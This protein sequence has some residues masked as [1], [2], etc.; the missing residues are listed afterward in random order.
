MSY[1]NSL[2]QYRSLAD[3]IRSG[4]YK[5]PAKQKA[6][7]VKQGLVA[8]PAR[9]ETEETQEVSR[10]DKP[11]DMMMNF[12]QYFE[13]L[14]RRDEEGVDPGDGFD[15][16]STYTAPRP[17]TRDDGGD[18]QP[19]RMQAAELLADEAFSTKLNEMKQK[20]PG[21][22]EGEL[23][24]VIKGESGFDL[25]ARN[26]SGATG[27]FQF[28]PATAKDL[29][30]TVDQIAKMSAGEQLALYDQYLE[31]WGYDGSISLGAMQAAPAFARKDPNTV[32]YPRG[33]AAWKQN[34]G[35][36]EN[37]DGDITL[38]SIDNYYRRQ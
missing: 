35:W 33:S 22:T 18:T 26:P 6:E 12:A 29:G 8:R 13:M 20:Y 37:G 21:L 11:E 15:T 2:N 30:V 31:K 19:L 4:E 16:Q 9:F 32:V 1:I 17:R 5:P 24:R 3:S 14:R 7:E 34:P 38:A 25:R 10:E 23:F 36:R 28:I 27:L